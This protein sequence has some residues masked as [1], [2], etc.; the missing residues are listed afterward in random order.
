[1]ISLPILQYCL[2]AYSYVCAVELEVHVASVN[3]EYGYS[4]FMCCGDDGFDWQIHFW[5]PMV[6]ISFA[7]L[8]PGICGH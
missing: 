1:M 7:L 3:L 6:F 5:P 2:K 8:L 4:H